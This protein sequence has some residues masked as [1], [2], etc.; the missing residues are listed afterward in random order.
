MNTKEWFYNKSTMTKC[1]IISV[2][3]VSPFYLLLLVLIALTLTGHDI[4]LAWIY[5]LPVYFPALI[6]SSFVEFDKSFDS[7][8]FMVVYSLFIFLIYYGIGYII[9]ILINKD[10]A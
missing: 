2:I 10:H 9:G 5:T 1:G 7:F 8:W 6:I 3:L 4:G